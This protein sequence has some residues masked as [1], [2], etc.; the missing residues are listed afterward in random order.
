MRTHKIADTNKTSRTTDK[1]LLEEF[2]TT[3]IIQESKNVAQVNV[4]YENSVNN[5]LEKA[6]KERDFVSKPRTWGQYMNDSNS[7]VLHKGKH[8]LHV[9]QNKL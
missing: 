5:R 9:F 6:G 3:K 8:Y 2:G 4:D 1:T 7:I